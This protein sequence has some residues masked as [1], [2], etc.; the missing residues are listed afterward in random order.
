MKPI[1]N[2]WDDFFE[3]ETKK[4][5][6]LNLREFL[7]TEYKTK[8]VYPGMDDIYSAFKSVPLEKVKVVI[9]GQDPYHQPGQAHGMSFSVMPGEKKPPSLVN[10]YKEITADIGCEM[11]ESGYLVPWAEQGV[12]LLNASL[13]VQRGNANSHQS[14]GWEIFT[15]EV[16]KKLNEHSSPKV[17]LLWGRNAQNKSGV[18]TNPAHLVLQAAHPSPFSAD[19][20]FFGCRHFSKAN[21]FLKENGLEP[22]DWQIV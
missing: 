2:S 14:I 15:N 8:T 20:G 6:Y 16:V 18:I 13:T 7:K 4:D 5:Y 3:T 22:I 11:G 19:N 17:F 21:E 12:F 10:M 1:G 9:L